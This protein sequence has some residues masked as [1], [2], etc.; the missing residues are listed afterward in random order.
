MILLQ[1]AGI[2]QNWVDTWRES[3]AVQALDFASSLRI[4]GKN[5]K[6]GCCR[7]ALLEQTGLA[8]DRSGWTSMSISFYTT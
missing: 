6:S 4:P 1:N 2:Q 5:R 7:S 3:I 8:S